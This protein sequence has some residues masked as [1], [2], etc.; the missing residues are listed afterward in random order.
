[1]TYSNSK[2]THGGFKDIAGN[3]YGR[4]TVVGYDGKRGKGHFWKCLCACGNFRIV[5]RGDL[6]MNRTKSCGC[7]RKEKSAANGKKAFVHGGRSRSEPPTPEYTSWL[8]MKA[9]CYKITADSYPNY[10]GRGI[11][12]C[13]RWLNSFEAFLEDMGSKPTPQHQIERIDNDRDYEPNNCKWA[14]P[15]EQGRNKRNN[16]HLTFG[17]ETMP[18]SAWAER[19][20]LPY[21]TLKLR[22][23]NGYSIE[24][25]LTMPYQAHKAKRNKP[26]KDK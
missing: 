7:L 17:G 12:V 14:T 22:L 4:L 15:K 10:G 21:N 26:P 9:R 23:R 24:K 6:T 3:R 8:S 25:A 5:R 1:M 19:V 13:D 2:P 18:M 16:H 20:G 11:K